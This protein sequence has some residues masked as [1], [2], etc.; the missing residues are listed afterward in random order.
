MHMMV[1]HEHDS[2]SV[3]NLNDG[4]QPAARIEAPRD[5]LA[6]VR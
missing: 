1:A 2:V 4:C 3:T 6:A 5:S